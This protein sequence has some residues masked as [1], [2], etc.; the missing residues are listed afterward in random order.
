MDGETL[1]KY[2]IG[3]GIKHKAP[4]ALS[5]PINAPALS[6]HHSHAYLVTFHFDGMHLYIQVIK[7]FFGFFF[8]VCMLVM[9]N[10]C[11]SLG[12]DRITIMTLITYKNRFLTV[13]LFI[14]VINIDIWYTS[15]NQVPIIV[16]VPC[17]IFLFISCL[18]LGY[19]LIFMTKR[20]VY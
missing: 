5:T 14:S 10:A 16:I 2:I 7:L 20:G 12:E 6:S 19:F 13:F 4:Q 9:K 15:Y 17:I 11:W 3:H 1:P 8:H 18:K